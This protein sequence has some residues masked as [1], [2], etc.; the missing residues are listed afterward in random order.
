MIEQHHDDLPVPAAGIRQAEA[1]AEL[2][3]GVAGQDDPQ[4]GSV[5]DGL[6]QVA[7]QSVLQLRV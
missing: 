2:V 4:L 5:P 3:T 7:C 6:A 1:I